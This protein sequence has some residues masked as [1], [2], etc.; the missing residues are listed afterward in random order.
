MTSLSSKRSGSCDRLER[1]MEVLAGTVNDW[2]ES[3]RGQ[4]R[5][6]K[7]YIVCTARK[8]RP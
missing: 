3:D 6:E 8:R 5:D 4:W 2:F 7:G 1:V